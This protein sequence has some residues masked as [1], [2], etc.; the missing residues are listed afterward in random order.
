MTLLYV[1]GASLVVLVPQAP[2][3]LTMKDETANL[4][5]DDSWPG[6]KD[7]SPWRPRRRAFDNQHRMRI[8]DA[9]TRHPPKEDEMSDPATAHDTISTAELAATVELACRAP[10][11]HNSQPWRWTFETTLCICLPTMPES[12]ATPTPPGGK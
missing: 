2:P 1:L 9:A 4:S 12:V 10:S 6:S 8:D 7:L 11:L 3:N 5:D